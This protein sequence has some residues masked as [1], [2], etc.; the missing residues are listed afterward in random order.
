MINNSN[1]SSVWA[2]EMGFDHA[3]AGIPDS[4]TACR[5]YRIGHMTGKAQRQGE[6]T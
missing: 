2:Y 5:E 6:N 1:Q 3:L 4:P